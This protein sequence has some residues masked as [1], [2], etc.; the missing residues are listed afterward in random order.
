MPPAAAAVPSLARTALHQVGGAA[1]KQRWGVASD[2]PLVTSFPFLDWRKPAAPARPDVHRLALVGIL[3][4]ASRKP[5]DSELAALRSDI[6][7]TKEPKRDEF[8]H[9]AH[10]LDKLGA[11]DSVYTSYSAWLEGLPQ[12]LSK[13][14]SLDDLRLT[15]AHFADGDAFSDPNPSLRSGNPYTGPAQ[16]NYLN[17]VSIG[18]LLDVD[19]NC[20]EADFTP[21]SLTRAI[22][23]LGEKD[24]HTVRADDMSAIRLTSESMVQ[25]L[26]RRS[27][28]ATMSDPAL[29]VAFARAMHELWLP[30]VYRLYTVDSSMAFSELSAAMDFEQGSPALV[31]SVEVARILRT[32]SHFQHVGVVLKRFGDPHLAGFQVEL[33]ASTLLKTSLASGSAMLTKLSGLDAVLKRASWKALIQHAINAQPGISGVDLVSVIIANESGIVSVNAGPLPPTPGDGPTDQAPSMPS[34]IRAQA[35]GDALRR[36]EAVNALAKARTLTGVE[37][38]EVLMMSGST[39]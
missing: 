20:L 3:L 10:E 30:P 37:R 32:A 25:L 38:V 35:M 21:T 36:S 4:P 14:G 18:R 7:L 16:L 11:Y 24:D 23:I 28:A 6:L 9:L 13:L 33:M 15:Q 31:K 2:S 22:I 12:L 19:N 8:Q 29:A 17:K 34:S 27:G 26:L 5:E 1:N 39:I